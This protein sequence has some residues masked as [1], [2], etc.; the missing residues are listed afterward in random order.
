MTATP[1]IN[2]ESFIAQPENEGRLFEF[3]EGEII[4]VSPGRTWNSEI[5]HLIIVALHFFCRQR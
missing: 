1:I 4:E 3:I 5:A 2:F